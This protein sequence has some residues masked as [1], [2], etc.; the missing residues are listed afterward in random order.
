MKKAINKSILSVAVCV[1]LIISSLLWL[2]ACENNSKPDVSS[3]ESLSSS[4][5]SE[6]TSSESSQESLSSVEAHEHQWNGGEVTK[7][8]TCIEEGEKTFTCTVSGCDGI[9]KESI[10]VDLTAHRLKDVGKAYV[11][12]ENGID[13]HK[14][15]E[16]CHKVFATDGQET[17]L[18]ALKTLNE[19]KTTHRYENGACSVCG[20]SKVVS[21]YFD[22]V[23]KVNENTVIDDTFTI[24]A[25]PQ[26]PIELKASTAT[27][28]GIQFKNRITFIGK[29]TMPGS[30]EGEV[31]YRALK[32]TSE[33]PCTITVYA[34]KDQG[35]Y[36]NIGQHNG[37]LAYS[38]PADGNEQALSD[39]IAKHEFKV[40][41]AGVYYIG[42]TS[43]S[44]YL[45]YASVEYTLNATLHSVCEDRH[46]DNGVT[47]PSTCAT[48]GKTVYTCLVCGKTK[49]Q[50]LPIDENNH[51]LK[52][53]ESKTA[54][55]AEKGNFEHQKCEYCGKLYIDGAEVAQSD[56]EIAMISS[57]T[58]I[59]VDAV[60]GSCTTSAVDAHKKCSVCQ[61][62]FTT[63]GVETT[64]EALSH[65]GSHNFE[66]HICSVCGT[67]EVI[68]TDFASVTN[69]TYTSDV[70]IDG[71]FSILATSAKN[72]VV[73]SKALDNTVD[74]TALSKRITLGGKG[75]LPSADESVDG[76]RVLAVN[77]DAPCTVIVYASGNTA[78]LI[79]MWSQKA[80]SS[81]TDMPTTGA[82]TLTKD[83]LISYVFTATEAGTYYIGSTAGS[84][85]IYSASVV[86][87]A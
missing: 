75:V 12:F 36:I 22:S 1:V 30:V 39:T 25:T 69:G 82:Q 27:A 32:I 59:D 26:K 79:N 71:T 54:T 37:E 48:E 51:S 42:T 10:P 2:T 55:C 87:N 18:E 47:I 41:D 49:E 4:Q 13:A 11:C 64:I 77:V 38:I 74:E 34:K 62:V 60:S 72:I 86:Y 21:T 70:V 50:S 31:G 9:K 46:Y 40:D 85:F 17:T 6:P 81:G 29:G 63:E 28:D 80:P 7:T 78:T 20:K 44:C 14:E 23:T 73:D 83:V 58:L 68:L 76:Y 61:K 16:Y 5:N 56:V 45:Y 19:D 35:S 43:S 67:N 24:L 66:N 57:H 84:C 33:G 15:C 3:S 52:T 65:P 8:A 53:V